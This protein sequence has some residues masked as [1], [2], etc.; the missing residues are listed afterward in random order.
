MSK[1]NIM[2]YLLI[3]LASGLGLSMNAQTK[4]PVAK[5]TTTAVKKT[6]APIQKSLLNTIEDS[7]SYALGMRVAG[8]FKDEMK[9][10][11]NVQAFVQAI[12]SVLENK[13]TLIKESATDSVIR[14]FYDKEKIKEAQVVISAGEKFLA[15]NKNKS[16]VQV[17]PSGLQYEIIKPGTGVKPSD[18]DT[19]VCNYRGTL[20]DGTQFDASYDRGEPLTVTPNRVIKGWTEG[21]QL[22]PVGATYKFYIPYQ[23][24][25]GLRGAGHAIPPGAALIFEVELLDVKKSVQ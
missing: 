1:V 3:L 12:K 20:I 16:G 19:V 24:A 4:K 25:Y 17:T 6:T 5:K 21:L 2:K 9:D 23:L 13:T 11:L 22:M 18:M 10:N 14:A 8:T 7:A 15:A